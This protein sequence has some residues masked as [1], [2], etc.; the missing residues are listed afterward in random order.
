MPLITVTGADQL[1]QQ[2]Q[3]C[4]C[5]PAHLPLPRAH[6]SCCP[7]IAASTTSRNA[8]ARPCRRAKPRSAGSRHGR[9][10]VRAAERLLV[11]F[12]HRDLHR[13]PIAL[14]C[15]I[16]HA[17][18]MSGRF[19]LQHHEQHSGLPVWVLL[20]CKLHPLLSW[21]ARN[22]LTHTH[23]HTHCLSGLTSFT[24]RQLRNP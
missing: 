16:S 11:R 3:H 15:W 20:S 24:R 8:C 13:R 2:Q 22:S 18:T 1:Q 9:S 19:L 7:A 23:T 10:Q 5:G 21:R 17:S 6:I 4:T 12:V 14:S